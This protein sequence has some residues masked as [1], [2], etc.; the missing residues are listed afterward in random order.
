MSS[1]REALC[2]YVLTDKVIRSVIMNLF[3]RIGSLKF[4]IGAMA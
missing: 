3:I 1:L 4:G 2:A